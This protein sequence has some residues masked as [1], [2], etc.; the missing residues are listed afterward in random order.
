[1]YATHS[2]YIYRVYSS[3]SS[4][5]EQAKSS[6]L[7]KIIASADSNSV[8]ILGILNYLIYLFILAIREAID[9]KRTSM[10]IR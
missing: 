2:P 5:C 7:S 10:N 6:F 1:M 8:Y 9:E 3:F 4:L